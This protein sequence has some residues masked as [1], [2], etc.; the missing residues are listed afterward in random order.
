MLQLNDLFFRNEILN[1]E[2]QLLKLFPISS[3]ICKW[4]LVVY[5]FQVLI[6]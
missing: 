1:L 6:Y 4:V 2:I 5:F 3:F